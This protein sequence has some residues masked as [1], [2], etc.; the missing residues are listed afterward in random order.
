M[1]TPEDGGP[2]AC[3]EELLLLLLLS[4]PSPG[5]TAGGPWMEFE[6][7]LALRAAPW[8]REEEDGSV[9]VVSDEPEYG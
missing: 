5:E 7:K 8:S 6:F 4:Q 9:V 1:L 3:K 2:R